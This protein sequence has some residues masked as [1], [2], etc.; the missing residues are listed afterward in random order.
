MCLSEIM[1]SWKGLA[2]AQEGAKEAGASILPI[3]QGAKDLQGA[4]KPLARGG[5]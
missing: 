4:P 2:L 1:V 3:K 5:R